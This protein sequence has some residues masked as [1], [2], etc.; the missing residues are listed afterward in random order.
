VGDRRE[1]PRGLSLAGGPA[2][3]GE[4]RLRGDRAAQKVP[5]QLGRRPLGT[6]GE[7]ADQYEETILNPDGSTYLHQA[8]DLSEHTGHGSDKAPKQARSVPPIRTP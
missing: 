6:S 4:E 7:E 5:Q 1:Q 3:V 2:Q 8:Q